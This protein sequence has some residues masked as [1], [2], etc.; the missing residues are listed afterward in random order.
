MYATGRDFLKQDVNKR[1]IISQPRQ[2]LAENGER[3]MFTTTYPRQSLNK[4]QSG[5]IDPN[6]R[7]QKRSLNS[8]ISFTN[9]IEKT[10]RV[11][12]QFSTN[13]IAK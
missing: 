2:S 9:K 10:A 13:D 4:Q 12:N 11:Y 8:P 3:I 1:S 5:S 6:I 7:E